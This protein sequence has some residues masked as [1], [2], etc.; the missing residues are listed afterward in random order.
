MNFDKYRYRLAAIDHGLF[1]FV[2]VYHNEWPVVL[3]TNPKH[4]LYHL[5]GKERP[6]LQKGK[7]KSIKSFMHIH[8][9]TFIST[10]STHIRL[11]AFSSSPIVQCSVR[12][13]NQHWEVCEQKAPHLFVVKWQAETYHSGIHKLEVLVVD[14]AGN[15]KWVN[16]PFSLDG[17][18]PSFDILARFVLMSDAST[19][20]QILFA[21]ALSSCIVPLI[22]LRCWHWLVVC[23]RLNR[24]RVSC[25]YPFK[26]LR[27]FWILSTI[28]RLVLPVIVYCLYLTVGPWSIGEVID[29]HMGIIFSWGIYVNGGYLPGS[30][31]YLYGFFQLLLCQ[32]PLMHIYAAHVDR[33]F[34]QYTGT[35]EKPFN[36]FIRCVS[37]FPF[38]L[39]IGI[40][41]VLAFFFWQAYGTL[42]F[43]LGPFRTWSVIMNLLL[44]K[45]ARNIPD[46]C[47]R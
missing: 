3:V 28:D 37:H 47:L 46:K 42:A 35:P 44:W 5:P 1:S 10:E 30:L 22:F 26:L 15:K 32:L 31:T 38:V 34:C 45:M 17:S 16:Q 36:S 39:I 40:E 25:R 23:G 33:R 7:S 4:A 14:S 24:P 21:I 8:C 19:I 12:L 13:N 41:I 20:F 9:F 6:E 27:R 29:G 43:L 2:D 11:L 18:R